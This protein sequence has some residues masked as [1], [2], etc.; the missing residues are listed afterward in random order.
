MLGGSKIDNA[1]R[2]YQGFSD[3]NLAS[4]NREDELQRN[5]DELEAKKTE[6]EKST[7]K[8][9]HPAEIQENNAYYDNL[10]LEVK[11]EEIIFLN[12]VFIP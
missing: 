6:L 12:D 11:Q 3:Q 2:I 9:Q 4:K 5:I 1:A 8:L 10:N 7:T